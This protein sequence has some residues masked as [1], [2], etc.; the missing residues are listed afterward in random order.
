MNTAFFKRCNNMHKAVKLMQGKVLA[1]LR[2]VRNGKM[3]KHA[4][5]DK[6]RHFTNCFG[7]VNRGIVAAEALA[8]QPDARHARVE[9]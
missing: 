5:R 9:L 1:I 7:L 4:L 2:L 6:S 3:R 8:H